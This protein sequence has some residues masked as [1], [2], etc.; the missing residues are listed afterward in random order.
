MK[1][2]IICVFITFIL[3][4]TCITI[5]AQSANVSDLEENMEQTNYVFNPEISYT[6]LA[7]LV[8]HV[9]AY[10]KINNASDLYDEAYIERMAIE[11]TDFE[12]DIIPHIEGLKEYYNQNFGRLA[13]INFM[14]FYVGSL[15][16]L[17]NRLSNFQDFTSED[18]DLFINP[19]LDILESESVFYY[20][21]WDKFHRDNVEYRQ[22]VENRLKAELHKFSY[23][24]KYHNVQPFMVLSYSITRWGR[25]FNRSGYVSSAVPFPKN[26]NDFNYTL[27]MILH[28]HTH[29]FTNALL[30]GNISMDDD[31]FDL[32]ESLAILADYYLIKAVDETLLPDYFK[33]F[34]VE[35]DKDFL[36]RFVIN[37]KLHGKLMKKIDDILSVRLYWNWLEDRENW[38]ITKKTG[39]PITFDSENVKNGELSVVIEQTTDFVDWH[40]IWVP[41]P[42]N[43]EGEQITLS[44][45]IK[46]ENVSDGYASLFME[47]NPQLGYAYLGDNVVTGT[48]D[49]TRYEISLN[50][51]PSKTT[52]IVIGGVLVGKGK[53][54]LNDLRV[55][56]D[57]KDLSE[58]ITI[59]SRHYPAADDKEFDE[60]SKVEFSNLNEEVIQNLELLGRIWGFLKYHHPEI[61][62]GK[63][64][65]D[66]ELFRILPEFL[67]IFNEDRQNERDLLILDWISKLGEI[68]YDVP[69]PETQPDAYLKPDF[70]WLENSDMRDDLKNRLRE[71]YIYRNQDEN[72]YLSMTP[73]V[74]NPIFTFE[75]AYG[76]MVF[77]DPG[78]RLLSLYR[79]WNMINYF[80]PYKYITDKDWNDVLAE[81]IPEFLK[82]T[83]RYEYEIITLKLIAEVQDTHAIVSNKYEIE[84]K[85][86][87]YY[88]PFRVWFVE[89]RLVVVDY[90]NPELKE[91]AGLEIGDI[92]THI[93]GE[94]VESIVER[95][96]TE[97][98][99]SNQAARLTFISK[100]ILRS[101]E[102]TIEIDYI[103][104]EIAQK[105]Q[106]E[107]YE[108]E[109][110]K[111]YNR[112]FWDVKED[113]V[114]YKFVDE[115]IGYINMAC[116]KFE[117]LPKIFD[118]F[119]DTKGIII[120]I[121]NY[122]SAYV[123]HHLGSYFVSEP[124]PFVKFTI[125]N[126]NNPG[127]FTFTEAYEIESKGETYKGKLIVIVN[128]I[129][130]SHAEFSAMAYRVGNNTTIVGSTTAAAD[131][132]VSGITLPGAIYTGISGIGVYYPDGTQTQRIGIVPDVWVEPTIEGTRQGRDEVL[133]KAVEII[134]SQ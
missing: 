44:G 99:A 103:S 97:Y 127:E 83:N 84:I 24:Y 62:K 32:S 61:A 110:I 132:N 6:Q 73:N 95:L 53:M 129:S 64:N 106:L 13:I 124:T 118:H 23:I 74:D 112:V 82:A 88:P 41:L 1:K 79:F 37:E 15:Q 96:K 3:L 102:N 69:A 105:K 104:K 91:T 93:K 39:Y 113:D 76:G 130:V 92:I 107:L 128:E 115:N 125:G 22:S 46:T 75:R 18:K 108:K 5:V 67:Q 119:K 63:Y 78:F 81:Y 29:S 38:K 36:K 50:M 21:Y 45:Y 85:R 117:D 134:R 87:D 2:Q 10:M 14:P 77:P 100:D 8:F 4:I 56:I 11:K 43:Y 114:S 101:T 71:I 35:S 40:A 48:T 60:G 57:K 54:W 16:D 65:C 58:A 28:E 52:S 25:G 109:K 89:N 120:D 122:P 116:I 9:L 66:Y 111:F 55:S 31:S 94:T 70:N 59:E 133:E 86:G 98:P 68:N 33:V 7:D 126:K 49:W 47:V 90:F 27:I 51:T 17:R 121:R 19:F 26:D 123:L 42:S 20:D 72:Y 131:G 34:G 30:N 12:Y 80:F